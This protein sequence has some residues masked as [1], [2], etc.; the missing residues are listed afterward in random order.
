MGY[1]HGTVA[2]IADSADAEMGKTQW[3]AEHTWDGELTS[4]TWMQVPSIF[5]LRLTGTG[6]VT[7]DAKDSLGN[8]TTGVESYAPSGA[9][10]EIQYPF[11]GDD[12]V[13]IRV[14]LTGSATAEV[15]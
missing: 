12:A 3:N 2:T 9:T 10:D 4:G 11:L 13:S 6:T 8:I 7:V 14:T 5:R 15:I 1:F